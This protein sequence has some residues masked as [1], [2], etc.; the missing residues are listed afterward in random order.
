MK[1]VILLVILAGLTSTHSYAMATF[2][3]CLRL[4]QAAASHEDDSFQF[5]EF[6]AVSV[7]K[8][9][10]L[11]SGSTFLAPGTTRRDLGNSRFEVT[12]IRFTCDSAGNI[13]R[14][15]GPSDVRNGG[16]WL[17][18]MNMPINVR[19]KLNIG[20]V[21]RLIESK[22]R[23]FR[24]FESILVR[25]NSSDADFPSWTAAYVREPSLFNWR[26]YRENAVALDIDSN[27]TTST[28]HSRI[29]FRAE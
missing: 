27:S 16:A 1:N 3:G 21:A 17:R 13:R 7:G 29:Y 2:E 28:Q 9:G 19:L 25:Y 12:P 10:E 4:V 6:S 18:D 5:A 26:T 23:S 14:E 22:G 8:N 24:G 20:Q 11:A 15:E